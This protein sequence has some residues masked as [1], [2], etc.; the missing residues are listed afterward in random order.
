MFLSSFTPPSVHKHTFTH[1]PTHIHPLFVT[2]SIL[3]SKFLPST[4]TMGQGSNGHAYFAKAAAGI[5]LVAV[6]AEKTFSI[7]AL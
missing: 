4:S 5:Q 3:L 2:F 7:F 1:T 6:L